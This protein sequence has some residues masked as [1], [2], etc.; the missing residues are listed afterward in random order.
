MSDIMSAVEAMRVTDLA[1][2]DDEGLLADIEA[3]FQARDVI[4][5]LIARRLH[6]AHSRESTVEVCGR[7]TR[8]WLVEEMRLSPVE[9]GRRMAVARGLSVTPMVGAA[10]DAGDI[11]HDHARAIMTCLRVM[12]AGWRDDAEAILVEASRSLDP[13]SL[14]QVSDE[15]RLRSGADESREAAEQRRYES[16]W[17]TTASTFDGMI[18]LDA[19]LDPVNGHTVLTALNALMATGEPAPGDT[20]SLGDGPLPRTVGQRRADALV[21]LARH[22]LAC[23]GLPET[24]GEKPRVVVTIDWDALRQQTGDGDDRDSGALDRATVSPATAR[25]LACDAEILPAVLGSDG[26]VLDLG[27]TTRNWITSQRRAARLRDRGCT[28]PKCRAGLDRCDLHHLHH[29]ADGGPTDLANSA[30]LCQ[31]HHWLVH[32]TRWRIRRDPDGRIRVGRQRADVVV[33]TS[34]PAWS[35]HAVAAV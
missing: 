2:V 7:S 16:R 4:D 12:P 15:L 33:R 3:L 22:S 21:E 10:L 31:F 28:Y 17:A 14:G 35:A 20:P 13:G 23:G 1:R 34:R 18:H 32:H 24:G 25:Q 6:A 26:A 8:S 27:R 30:H 11:S 29:W 9:A 5:G 19:M